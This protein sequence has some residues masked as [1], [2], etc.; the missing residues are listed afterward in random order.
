MLNPIKIETYLSFLRLLLGFSL[1]ARTSGPAGVL[2]LFLPSL[3]MFLD[4]LTGGQ[5]RLETDQVVCGHLELSFDAALKGII[6]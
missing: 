1:L 3:A 6:G 2:G 4:E 5:E